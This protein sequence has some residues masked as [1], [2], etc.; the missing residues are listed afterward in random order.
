MKRT[1]HK[2]R[3]PQHKTSERITL[4]ALL[5]LGGWAVL[6]PTGIIAWSEAMAKRDQRSQ[7]IVALEEE[8]NQLSN[9]VALLDPENA[10][11]DMVGE[12]LRR[13]LNVVHPDEVV[14]TIDDEHLSG[15]VGGGDNAAAAPPSD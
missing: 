1:R 6:G 4:G 14:L 11:P 5:F 8:I 15:G 10:D 13:D 2:V 9:R 3:L 7:Q 12:L